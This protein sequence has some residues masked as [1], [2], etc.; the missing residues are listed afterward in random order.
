MAT[1]FTRIIRGEIPGTFVWR[2]DRAVAFLSI[3]P[4]TTGHTL[5]V[6]VAEVDQWT[7]LPAEVASHL[8]EV[9]H[10]IGRAQ[11]RA[12]SPRRVGLL[13]AGFEVPH[14]HLHVIPLNS[15][16]DFALP[17]PPENVDVNALAAAASKIRAELRAIDAPAISD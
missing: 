2:D 15:M 17:P 3:A 12:F 14:T 7:D 16:A 9:A 1:L 10:W 4:A 5:V 13:V 8:M 6:P 11:R